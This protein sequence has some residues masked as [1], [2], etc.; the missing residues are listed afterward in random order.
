[1][2][3]RLKTA[4]PWLTALGGVAV[5]VLVVLLLAGDVNLGASAVPALQNLPS[6]DAPPLEFAYLDSA[7]VGAYLGQLENGLA[8]NEQ[9]TQQL[10]NSVNA[11]LSA[12]SAAQLAKAEQTQT[13]TSE[14]V[15]PTAADRFY[16]FLRLLRKPAEAVCRPIGPNP[17]GYACAKAGCNRSLRTRWLGEVDE[18]WSEKQ[19]I[20]E[21]GCI[22][23]GNFIR[24]SHAELFLPP[25]VQALPRAQSADAFY[26][27]LPPRRSPFTSPT[28]S[29]PVRAGLVRYSKQVGQDSRVP[30]IAAPYGSLARIGAGVTFFLPLS[31]RGLTAEPAL[32]SGSVTI[33]GKVIYDAAAGSAYIDYPTISAFET[34]L[35]KAAP[36]FVNSLGVCAEAA[37]VA[38]RAR[39][40]V[41]PRPVGTCAS[42]QQILDAVKASVTFKPPIVVVPPIA[43]YQ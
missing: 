5:V 36:G 24:I 22:N 33:V 4:S 26:G 40:G 9:R 2:A 8:P 23:V 28:Q 16:M 10:S 41:G 1:M 38:T 42:H 6:A 32:L 35:L 19:V 34:P 12:G 27:P 11:S 7:R 31:Y 18:E 3:D 30:V 37:P 39:R 14:T 20:D 25:Y 17:G 43:I 29:V 21:V 13:G 15:A